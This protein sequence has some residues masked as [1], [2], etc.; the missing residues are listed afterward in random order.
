VAEEARAVEHGRLS[1][2]LAAPKP[3]AERWRE[4]GALLGWAREGLAHR[5]LGHQARA[6]GG[7]ATDL[8]RG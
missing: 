8:F 4:R 7:P 6:R 2:A 5:A 1:R 3:L